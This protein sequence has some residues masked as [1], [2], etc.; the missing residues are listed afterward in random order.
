MR[1]LVRTKTPP[2]SMGP[3]VHDAIRGLNSDISIDNPTTLDDLLFTSLAPERFSAT[4]LTIFAALALVLASIGIYGVTSYG[5]A[6][7]SHEIGIRLAIG[8]RPGNVLN[9]ILKQGFALALAG[10]AIGVFG[11][12][13]LTRLIAAML[14]GV[15]AHDP[16]TIF[17]VGGILTGVTLLACLIPA[18]R[19]MRL[20][21]MV[22]L[23]H[24]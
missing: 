14:F 4:L 23:R 7:R 6:Q 1:L 16:L 13:T 18:L 11:A 22:I 21:P 2:Y 24:D 19:A 5:V 20:D 12:L 17:G 15:T 9:M 3:A 10:V 8:A